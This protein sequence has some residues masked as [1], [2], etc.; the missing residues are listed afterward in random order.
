MVN[1]R[2]RFPFTIFHLPLTGHF[3]LA[4]TSHETRPVPTREPPR[5]TAHGRAGVVRGGGRL[6]QRRARALL[7]RRAR[8]RRVDHTPPRA[9]THSPRPLAP[10]DQA[11][12]TRRR[13]HA[14]RSNRRH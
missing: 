12:L 8:G 9:S 6:R 4:L 11:G 2:R 5:T 7:P 3:H 10:T 14:L 13:P 1:G